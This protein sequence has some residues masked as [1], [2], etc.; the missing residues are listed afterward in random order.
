MKYNLAEYLATKT[1]KQITNLIKS[2]L[3]KGHNAWQF[4]Y[5]NNNYPLNEVPRIVTQ[6]K[7]ANLVESDCI[8][9]LFDAAHYVSAELWDQVVVDSGLCLEGNSHRD[10]LEG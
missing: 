5:D 3:V 1:T 8:A 7:K 2:R 4:I 9:W 10:I 6:I